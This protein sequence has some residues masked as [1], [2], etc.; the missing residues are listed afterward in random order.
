[1][2]DLPDIPDSNEPAVQGED[3]PPAQWSARDWPRP[4]MGKFLD[5][6]SLSPV[7]QSAA[8]AAGIN[9]QY[10][11]E[12]AER[13]PEFAEAWEEARQQG[14]DVLEQHVHRWATVGVT[15]TERREKRNERGEVVESTVTTSTSVS[16]TLAMFMLKR[17]RPEYR[18]THNVEHSGRGGGPVQLEVDR[19]PTRERMVAL[20][21]LAQVLELPAAESDEG[22]VVDGSVV[23]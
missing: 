17:F 9:R 6:L 11:Y 21:K 12:A 19:W 15:L 4:W 1:M 23:E 2:T 16:P 18:E 7:V 22:D 13:W 14:V 3:G 8:R 5:S 20:A 10:A